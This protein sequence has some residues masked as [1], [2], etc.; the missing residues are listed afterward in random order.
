M[1]KIPEVNFWPLQVHAWVNALFIP[2]IHTYTHMHAHVHIH[3]HTNT[4]MR[5]K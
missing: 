4:R 5:T 2:Q 1:R 3:M